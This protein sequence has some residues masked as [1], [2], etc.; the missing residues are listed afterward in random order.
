MVAFVTSIVVLILFVGG[1]DW[2]R[3]RTPADKAFTWGEAMLF[4]GC[5]G[6]GGLRPLQEVLGDL[7]QR[8]LRRSQ[9]GPP[10]VGAD[11]RTCGCPVLGHRQASGHRRLACAERTTRLAGSV[12]SWGRPGWCGRTPPDGATGTPGIEHSGGGRFRGLCDRDLHRDHR[13]NG[14]FRFT[15]QASVSVVG[16]LT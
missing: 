11:P 13:R 10:I 8:G 12:G 14:P 1:A 15:D 7:G 9:A 16:P 3:K 2:Y 5:L 6:L 4:A